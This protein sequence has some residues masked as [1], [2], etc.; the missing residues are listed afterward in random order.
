MLLTVPF[1]SRQPTIMETVWAQQLSTVTGNGERLSCQ[2]EPA[3]GIL[4]YRLELAEGAN[5]IEIKATDEEG[6]ATTL[7]PFTLYK[8]ED[9]GPQVAGSITISIEAGTVGL[10]TILPATSIDYYQGEQLSSV[11][12]RLCRTLVLTG[13]TMGM[14]PAALFKSHWKGRHFRKCGYPG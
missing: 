5:T 9:A 7:P 12:L 13:E 6:Y 2:G 8:G 11:L 3:A 10:G 4:A 14:P 1:T